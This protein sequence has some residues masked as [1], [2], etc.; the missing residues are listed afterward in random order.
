MLAG[1]SLA[2]AVIAVVSIFVL[3]RWMY[4][5]GAEDARATLQGGLLTAA[6][7]LLAVAG[8]LIALDETRQANAEVRQSNANT[9]VR[10]L[11]T[12]AIE[13]LGHDRVDVR[14]G[15]LYALERVANDSPD[16]QRTVVE[17]LSAFVREHSPQRILSQI[18][19]LQ[20]ATDIQ[21][22]L[23]ILGRLPSLPGVSRADLPQRHLNGAGLF[24]ANL[25]GANLLAVNLM[26]AV[27]TDANMTGTLMA[28]VDLTGSYLDGCNLS[29]AD[30]TGAILQHADI[31]RANLRE[32]VGL[33]QV[34]V[35]SA[36]GD[37]QTQ[38]PDGLNRPAHWI[39]SP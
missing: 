29:G 22:A 38:L 4:G 24:R 34:Q 19:P 10:E 32:V 14:L 35:D 2:L 11:Y 1:V 26:N 9:H 30:L 23:T 37:E 8:G 12:S 7:A 13:L 20:L 3:P 39:S 18:L 5:S 15:G 36:R 28:G 31:S 17:V 16:D 25:A 6:A 21:T 27:M 33:T